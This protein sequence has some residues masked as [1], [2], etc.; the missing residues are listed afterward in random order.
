[1]APPAGF[2]TNVV[3]C[4]DN[5]PRLAQFPAACV[6]LVYLDPPFFSNRTHTVTWG[7]AG[8]TR[9]FD[10]RWAGNI[11]GYV[12]WMAERMV[13]VARV[14]KPTG[15]VYLHCDWHACHYL[16]VMMDGVFGRGNFLNNVVWCY[17]L[18]G[19]SERYWPRKHDDI[20]WYSKE[21]DGHF[22]QADR[23]PATSQRMK[24]ADKKAPDYWDI[25]AVNNMANERLGY[26][27][28]KPEAL[29]RRIVGSSSRPGD[30]VLDPFA[31]SGTALV[32][33]HRLGR[34]WVGIDASPA[35]VAL[36]RRRLEA[37][38]DPTPVAAPS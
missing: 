28:Q 7:D 2:E 36:A 20:L 19:S 38:G 24:G 16:K 21:P 22:F 27:T 8:E 5:L 18:G 26:P 12:G 33:A 11:D 17:G 1:M 31:G 30:V 14:L 9:S 13:Q 37:A 15:S 32:V 25:P 4:D 10:D 29:L 23:V 35:A 6:D 34:R 3:Y